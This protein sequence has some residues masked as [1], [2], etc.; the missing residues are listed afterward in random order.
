MSPLH[1]S[2]RALALVAGTLLAP[3]WA[4]PIIVELSAEA[5]RPAVNDLV[6]ATV[7]AEASGTTPGELSRQVGSQINEA[8]KIARSYPAIRTQSG[9]TATYP[10][11]A[12]GGKIESWRM[13][14]ELALESVDAASVSE[15][16]GKLQASLGVSNLLL[17]P[18]PETRRK[19]ESEAMVDAIAAFKGQAKVIA[20]AL[21]MGYRIKQLSVSTSGR[22]VQPM[23]RGAAKA[24]AMDAAPMPV[25]AGESQVS[26]SV[27]GQIEV[28]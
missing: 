21:G 14:S 2:V 17:Q 1:H 19:V 28:E 26:V 4:A 10:V 8:L 20:D 5:S 18:S 24:M 16:L 15:L 9:N 6:R 25:E 3:V 22:I 7:S 27:S 11:Y 12:K 23:F 13:R